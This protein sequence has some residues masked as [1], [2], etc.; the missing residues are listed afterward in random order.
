MNIDPIRFTAPTT[1]RI[2]ANENS[3]R[4]F[5]FNET[6]EILKN[7][8]LPTHYSND[9]IDIKFSDQYM[10]NLL[11]KIKLT[12]SDKGIKFKKVRF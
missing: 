4:P 12:L 7:Q 8:H 9:K 10:S 6:M 3:N 2:L 11:E 5:L 1:I